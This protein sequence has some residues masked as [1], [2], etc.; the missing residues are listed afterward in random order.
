MLTAVEQWKLSAGTKQRA[1]PGG[2]K[3]SL[4]GQ[5]E[6][7]RRERRRA[8]RDR[9]GAE[10][11]QAP[12]AA[13]SCSLNG[14]DGEEEASSCEGADART[15]LQGGERG[16]SQLD[17]EESKGE[18]EGEEGVGSEGDNEVSESDV[19]SECGFVEEE[20]EEV[21]SSEGEM[22]WN[23]S[24]SES[25]ES[26]DE[27]EL[28]LDECREKGIKLQQRRPVQLNSD[29]TTEE[30]D[31]NTDEEG[32]G[33]EE[34]EGG[35]ED[36]AG[37]GSD[38]DSSGSEGAESLEDADSGGLPGH[39]R[40]KEGLEQKARDG[41]ERRKTR[42]VHLQRLI[43]SDPVQQS[44]VREGEGEEEEGESGGKGGEEV[45]G[46]FH[47]ARREQ[48]SVLHNEDCSVLA[49]RLTRDWTTCVPAVKGL[50]VTGSWGEEDAAELLRRDTEDYGDFED[51]E[52]GEKYGRGEE[53]GK[54]EE[55]RL[56]RKKEQKVCAHHM[57]V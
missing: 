34:E 3:N 40:W 2:N 20:A 51:L 57:T 49:Q 5:V 26:G 12:S 25:E 13:D 37:D 18:G 50:F 42:T 8:H 54:E 19:G 24:E 32:E 9:G 36:G 39:L 7:R 44:G 16:D 33:E 45:G 43:Y 4:L 35:L 17:S 27:E 55:K 53:E 56:Q 38:S 14:E 11:S 30:A 23:E 48:L 21:W 15:P 47:V 41:F 31:L 28:V 46:L 10:Q 29:L 22:E 1:R 52:T 6:V